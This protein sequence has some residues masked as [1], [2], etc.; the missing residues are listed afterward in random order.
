VRVGS[1]TLRTWCE[2]SEGTEPSQNINM[3]VREMN[4]SRAGI[5]LHSVGRKMWGGEGR[6]HFGKV[7]VDWSLT[8]LRGAACD[9]VHCIVW[10][11]VRTASSIL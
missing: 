9:C 1:G 11:G 4:V 3:K 5:Q 7:G 8:D 2:R 6:R 10:L